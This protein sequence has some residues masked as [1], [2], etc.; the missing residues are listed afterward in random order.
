MKIRDLFVADVTR[1]IPPVVYF[2]EQSPAKLRAEVGEYIITGGYPEGDPRSRRVKSGIHEQFVHL[3]KGILHELT[4]G[5][6]PELP[7]AWISGFY[8]SGKSSFAKLLGLALDGVALPDGTLLS[9][10]LLA[11]DDSPRRQELV[12]AWNA[13][14]GYVKPFAVVFDIGG[15]ARD[16]EHIHS[17]VLRL[18]QT[19]LGYCSKSSL[20]ADFEL[21]LERDGEWNAFLTTAKKTLGKEWQVAKEEEQAD[22]HFSHVLHVLKPDRYP[23]PT[24]WIDS[25]AGSRTGAGTSV[26]EVVEAIDAMCHLR[27]HDRALFIVVDEVSQYVHQDEGRMLKLQSFVSELGQ[28]LKGR[29]WLFATGQ[30]KLEDTAETNNLGKLKDRFPT[31]LRVHLGTT[32]I[33]DVVHKRLLKK[34][35]DQEKVLRTLYGKHQADLR[36]YG[37]AAAEIT[38][39]DFVETYP[40]LPGHIDLLMQVTSSLRTRST[41]VQGDDHAIRGLLQLLGE[42]FREQ[43]L[44]DGEVGSLVTLDAIFE[45]QHSALDADVQTTLSR[46]FNDPQVCDDVL[47]QR[48]AKAVAL[49]ELIQEQTPTIPEL[50]AQCLYARLGEGNRVQAV[51]EAL[52]KLRGLSLLSYSEK[53]GFKIQS[54]AGQEWQRE[55]DEIGVTQEQISQTAQGA[56]KNLVGSMQERPR[57]KGRN[58]PWT[59]WFSDGRQAH[60]VKLQDAREDSTVAVDFRFLAKKDDRTSTTW[61]P[62][63]DQELLRNRLLWVVGESGAI[64]DHARQLGRSERMLERYRPRRESLTREKQRLLI[65][66]EARFD[67]LEGNVRKAVAEAFLEGTAYFR[68]QQIRP[69]DIGSAF[70]PALSSIATRLLPDLYPHFSE[71]AILPAELNQLLEKELAGPST[72]FMEGGLGILALDA[73]KY[74]ASC[75]GL[76][77]TRIA[78]QIEEAGGLSGQTLVATFVSPPY[79]YASDL[80]KACCAG[81]LRG[82]KIRIRPEQGDD[83]TSYQDPG[84]RDLFTRDR[85]F[86]RA[87]FF[88]ATEGEV[89]G[90][91]RIAI[92]KLF[93][94]YLQVDL[95][96]DDEPIAD[97]TFQQFPPKREQLA[98]VQRRFNNLP[99]RPALPGALQKLGRALEDCC[100]SRLVQKTVVEV[101]RNLDTLRDGFQQLGVI[102]AELTAEAIEAIALAARTRDHE[103]GQLRQMEELAGLEDDA[104]VVTNHLEAERP[105]REAG[106]LTPAIER[107]RARYVEVRRGLLNRQNIE[108]EAARGRVKT[109]PGFA[110]LDADQAHRVLRPIGE[111]MV[112]T[113]AEA[114]SP[115]LAE[116]RDRFA[117]RIQHAEEMANDRLDEEISKTTDSQVVKVETRLRGREIAN[118]DQLDAVLK[119][120][121]ER[122]GPRLDEGAKVRLV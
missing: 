34:K 105:W 23:E 41:R 17:A 115:P 12:D 101:K 97:A 119:E 78:K 4:K 92:R 57:W 1:D 10:A 9:S 18:V 36:L 110:Q 93:A 81:L 31:H 6:G 65:E 32:N 67:E 118:R 73:G 14:A 86:R 112:D 49:L 40:M 63:S 99:Y 82:K 58:F 55:R 79:G 70:G 85:D 87:E 45:V 121:E 33:R 54:S 15:V 109:R 20:V 69:R 11:R 88:P 52:E 72:K 90:R 3:L 120:L 98:D 48:V 113:T 116:V 8:G 29:V 43:K 95:E 62:K 53:H 22:D 64:E 89:T 37:Y 75:T 111:V 46:I 91:D 16:N 114:I 2:H 102:Q 103:L 74:I 122:I 39:E 35:P 51:T 107:I 108:A 21:K 94:T 106:L 27:E 96:P 28:R 56:L 83:I 50:V 77:P 47:A 68:G 60:D 7:A 59:L 26:K 84:V 44:A 38:E 25:R 61:V 66:E 5:G 80:V 30:Q 24:S 13:L 19:R 104:A 71:I 42:L 117:S 76:Y 100:R